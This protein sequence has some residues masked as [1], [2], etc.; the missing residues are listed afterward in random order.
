LCLWDINNVPKSRDLAINPLRSIQCAHSGQIAEGLVFH[1]E[2]GSILSSVGADGRLCIWDTRTMSTFAAT[3]NVWYAA[4]AAGVASPVATVAAHTGGASALAFA[5]QSPVL[6]ATGGKDH[7]V[8]LWDLRRLGDRALDGSG[9]GEI[10]TMAG[11]AGSISHIAW[12]PEEPGILASASADGRIILWDPRRSG[13]EVHGEP[14]CIKAPN[15]KPI[16][17]AP[18]VPTVRGGRFAPEIAFIHEAHKTSV[19]ALSWAPTGAGCGLIASVDGAGGLHIWQP[20]SEIL[21]G[22]DE[23]TPAGNVG[24][25]GAISRSV[26]PQ[27]RRRAYRGK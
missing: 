21:S 15:A 23:M 6:I 26:S 5:P 8:R 10:S 17:S 18:E 9:N 3:S 27:S 20:S 16:Q 1:P 7:R 4:S 25:G 19:S 14:K 24:F 13:G 11:H 2:N 22:Y 12:D